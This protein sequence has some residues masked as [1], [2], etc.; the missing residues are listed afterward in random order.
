MR[1]TLVAKLVDCARDTSQSV[2]ALLHSCER[3]LEGG[4]CEPGDYRSTADDT[5]PQ[6]LLSLVGDQWREIP[7]GVHRLMPSAEQ[8][9]KEFSDW[10]LRLARLVLRAWTETE[11]ARHRGRMI[12][13][14]VLTITCQFLANPELPHTYTLARFSII[15]A[16]RSLYGVSYTSDS[17]TE[18]RR[19]YDL[20]RDHLAPARPRASKPAFNNH[21][22]FLLDLLWFEGYIHR[23]FSWEQAARYYD[24]FAR[25]SFGVVTRAG[26]SPAGG[27]ESSSL[28]GKFPEFGILINTAFSQ[29]TTIPG[30]D[31]VTGGLLASIPDPDAPLH[32]GLV[33]LI[34]GSPGTGK[35]TLCLS[36]GSRMAELGSSVRYIATEENQYS[37]KAKLTAIRIPLASWMGVPL[38]EKNG[39]D[40]EGFKIMPGSSFKNLESITSQLREDLIGATSLEQ[41][42]RERSTAQESAAGPVA[43]KDEAYV[44]LV[45][46]R[47]VIIDSLTALLDLQARADAGPDAP[48]TIAGRTAARR[49]LTRVLN[50][51]RALGICVFLVGGEGDC[52]DDG[53]SYLVD[54]VFTLTFEPEASR[55]HP[56]RIFSVEKTRLQT[57]NRG[58]HILHISG[59]GC[60]VSPSLHAVLKN[61]KQSSVRPP[62]STSRAVLWESVRPDQFT[63]WNGDDHARGGQRQSKMVTIRA[64]SQVLVYGRGPAGKSQFALYLAFEPRIPS[65]S[66]RA[67]SDDGNPDATEGRAA[68]RSI[69][70]TYFA[71][72]RVLVLSFLHGR[73]HYE[74]IALK[75]FQARFGF[76]PDRAAERLSKHIDVLDFYPGFV[77]PETLVARIRRQLREGELLGR[78]Y[79]AV[80]LDGV[81]NVLLQFPLLEGEPLLWSTLYR[82]F[83]TKGIEAI[84]TF[85]FFRIAQL[86]SAGGRRYGSA[87]YADPTGESGWMRSGS[88]GTGLHT[89]RTIAGSEQLFFHLLVS[90]CDYGFV[91]ETGNEAQ[92]KG[93]ATVQLASS[94]EAPQN[95][96][97]EASWDAVNFRFRVS[98]E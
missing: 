65:K 78:P 86:R 90:S 54:N 31:D 44:Y 61:L 70:S 88:T 57:S 67:R 19:S 11:M 91:I 46:P 83:R 49:E 41:S 84:S 6:K 72:S 51:L 97:A 9:S 96:P 18:L 17:L 80:V 93:D 47:V 24:T 29:P 27:G 60:T 13:P 21:T 92:P 22:R 1:P 69:E 20:L 64:R 52:R 71:R 45:F 2:A 16:L 10:E 32:G 48:G 82:L 89:E 30:L 76:S 14:N 33:T 25:H 42:L 66:I 26:G 74:E 4:L 23:Y 98:A 34:A 95:D 59:H 3:I 8:A 73:R 81:H 56:L 35:T 7:T 28:V 58:K 37:L 77:D 75:L 85:T 5:S 40:D 38:Q 63:I 39:Q 12:R 68:Q 87:A 53:L 43:E 55:R 62:D 15:L 36:I 79:T 94:V 50:E